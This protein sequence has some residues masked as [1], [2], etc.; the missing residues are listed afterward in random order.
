MDGLTVANADGTT[1]PVELSGDWVMT[2]PARAHS[3]AHHHRRVRRGPR[4]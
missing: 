2:A 3:G 4:G 1:R